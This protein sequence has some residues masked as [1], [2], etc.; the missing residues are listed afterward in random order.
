MLH[1]E[2]SPCALWWP[3]GYKCVKDISEEEGFPFVAKKAS[4]SNRKVRSTPDCTRCIDLPPH[5]LHRK[6]PSCGYFQKTEFWLTLSTS[7]APHE[8]SWSLYRIHITFSMVSPHFCITLA[9]NEVLELRVCH[10][11]P[12][13]N[14]L[15]D[16]PTDRPTDRPTDQLAHLCLGLPS[17][18][19]PS[20]F[21][22]KALYAPLLPP[23]WPPQVSLLD[24][25]TEWYLVRTTEHKKFLVM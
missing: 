8:L 14:L 2:W 11:W 21:P 15:T 4:Q 18:V 10:F 12:N 20:G 17:G 3:S 9:G 25:T 16:W 13:S 5:I 19:L 23:M 7:F 22:T 1:G 6:L 24:L